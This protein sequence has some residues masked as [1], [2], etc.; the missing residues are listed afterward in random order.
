MNR[1]FAIPAL[2]LIMLASSWVLA[3]RQYLNYGKEQRI[4]IEKSRR[5]A[6]ESLLPL[7]SRIAG[8]LGE[9][10]QSGVLAPKSRPSYLL[11]SRKTA[12]GVVTVEYGLNSEKSLYR[13]SRLETKVLAPGILQFWLSPGAEPL[14]WNL[15]LTAN[16]KV[17]DKTESAIFNFY[18]APRMRH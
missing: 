14:S 4:M 2:I 11:L 16:L 15:N 7:V 6:I 18:F 1:K 17:G 9:S 5:E 12:R 8:D 13:R 10:E 3:T